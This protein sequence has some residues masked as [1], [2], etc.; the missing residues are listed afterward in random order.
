MSPTF[1]ATNFTPNEH[2]GLWKISKIG[3]LF[4]VALKRNFYPPLKSCHF[5]LFHL[6]HLMN[7]YNHGSKHVFIV[8]NN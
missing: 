3:V 8:K 1:G 5:F 7:M 4:L 2:K 6:V